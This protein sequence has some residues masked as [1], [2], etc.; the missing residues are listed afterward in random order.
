[1]YFVG[2]DVGSSSI[3]T[4]P[5]DGVGD[6]FASICEDLVKKNIP[7][8]PRT[9]NSIKIIKVVKVKKEKSAQFQL[10]FWSSAIALTIFALGVWKLIELLMN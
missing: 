2:D 5:N 9:N 7:A 10:G 6:G 8:P 3:G 4:T 1:M